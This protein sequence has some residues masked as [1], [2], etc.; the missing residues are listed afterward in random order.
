MRVLKV[1][2][3]VLAVSLLLPWNSAFAYGAA[4]APAA[5]G[6]CRGDGDQQTHE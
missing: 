2:M 1:V 3:I 6:I 5:I 4:S